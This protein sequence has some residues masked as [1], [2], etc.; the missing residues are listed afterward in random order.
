[1]ANR[2]G[3]IS[4]QFYR[5]SAGSGTFLNYSVWESIAHYQTA[6]AKPELHKKLPAYPDGTVR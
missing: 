5:G 3:F 2:L 6:F 1:M 4:A